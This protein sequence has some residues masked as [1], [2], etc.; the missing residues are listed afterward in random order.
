MLIRNQIQPRIH[1]EQAEERVNRIRQVIDSGGYQS[2]ISSEG[3][4]GFIKLRK[5]LE[6]EPSSPLR[7]DFGFAPD[8]MFFVD[9]EVPVIRLQD[10][11]PEEAGKEDERLDSRR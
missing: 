10:E 6:R 2:G 5:L 11:G 9:L 8:D 7:L 4:T 1:N 3:G